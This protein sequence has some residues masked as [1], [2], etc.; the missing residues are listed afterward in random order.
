MQTLSTLSKSQG[1]L[2]TSY[3]PF[4]INRKED[5]HAQDV[6]PTNTDKPDFT[7]TQR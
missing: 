7:L 5:T 4:P 2:D 1:T 6:E 3:K